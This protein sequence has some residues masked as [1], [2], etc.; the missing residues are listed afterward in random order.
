M[1][2]RPEL[3][4]RAK[5]EFRPCHPSTSGIVP[6]HKVMDMR[7]YDVEMFKAEVEEFL[8]THVYD[9]YYDD[10]DEN[11]EYDRRSWEESS[12][13]WLPDEFYESN[14]DDYENYDDDGDDDYDLS[15]DD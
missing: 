2:D 11:T 3:D 1:I 5:M 13:E 9:C 6:P 12:L 4:S 14:D 10:D 7:N 8:P 15:Y